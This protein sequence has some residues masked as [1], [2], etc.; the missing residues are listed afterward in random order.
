VL[1]YD[2]MQ[3]MKQSQTSPDAGPGTIT[4]PSNIQTQIAA[5]IGTPQQFLNSGV[6]GRF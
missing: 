5:A 6:S 4:S 3:A 1:L 2:A